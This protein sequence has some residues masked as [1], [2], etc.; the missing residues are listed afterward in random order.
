MNPASR[1]G[2]SAQGFAM[3]RRVADLRRTELRPADAKHRFMRVSAE[4]ERKQNETS[5]RLLKPA[6]YAGAF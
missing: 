6:A 4:Q 3:E 2:G 5:C 1:A